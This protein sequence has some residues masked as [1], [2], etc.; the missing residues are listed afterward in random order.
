MPLD[1]LT[2]QAAFAAPLAVDALTIIAVVATPTPVLRRDGKGAFAEVLDLGGVDLAGLDLPLLDS[3]D[4]STT[5]AVLG[6]A[7]NFRREGDTILADLTFST[8]EDVAPIV[9]RVRDGTLTHFSI[10]YGVTRWAETGAGSDRIKRAVAWTLNEVSLVSIPADPNARKRSMPKDTQTEDR[11]ALITRLQSAFNLP[12]DWATR[13]ADAGA[14]LD[15]EELRTDA[16]EAAQAQRAARKPVTIRTHGSNDDPAQIVTRQADAVAFRMAGGDLPPASREFV[17]LSLMD[18]ARDSL[19]R[20]GV[21]T[22]GMSADEVLQRA[23]HTTSDFPLVV[24]NAANKVAL[25]AYKAAE[26]PLKALSRQRTLSDF[27]ASTSIRLGGMGRL[28]RMTESGEFTATSRAERGESMQLA[29]FGRRFDLSRNLI[30]NDDLNLLGDT[31]A[32]LGQA[33][34]QTEADLMLDLITSNPNLSDNVAV[35]H[36]SRDNIMAGAPL[37]VSGIAAARQVMRSRTDLDGK[38][39]ISTTPRFLLVGPALETEG[40]K[41]L[42]AIYAAQ[43]ADVNPFTGKLQLLVEPRLGDSL[44][45]FLFADP[46]RLPCL[47]HAYLSGAQGVQIQRQEA[48]NTLGLSFRAFLDFGA[49]WQDWRGVQKMAG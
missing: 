48:W 12:D 16:R 2:R 1:S 40:E 49:A 20:A 27:K 29:T 21:S 6:R 8:A 41:V 37:N 13:A 23:A 11:A 45:W 31:V 26:S 15:D 46:A 14:E 44:D 34:A 22:R 47:A 24:S 30:I 38:T 3:H 7:T 36:A 43:V 32:A 25:D 10:G 35:F 39:L 19:A 18:L 17:N 42:A 9:A 5:K 4:R 28:E 33:A